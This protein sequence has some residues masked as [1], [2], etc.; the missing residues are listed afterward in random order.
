MPSSGGLETFGLTLVQAK[1]LPRGKRRSVAGYCVRHGF[2]EECRPLLEAAIAEDPNAML[3]RT[4][5]IHVLM[6]CGEMD[7]AEDLSARLLNEFP[8]NRFVINTRA[9]VLLTLGNEEAARQVF[10]DSVGD[11][12]V[13]WTYWARAG[14]AAHRRRGWDEARFAL[15]KALA[16]YRSR[17]DEDVDEQSIPIYLWSALAEQADHD[18]ISPNLF[19]EELDAVR[20]AEQQ[21]IRAALASP[22]SERSSQ[23][24]R[25][26]TPRH[27]PPSQRAVDPEI[28]AILEES[29][30][31][32][33][34]NPALAAE[35]HRLFGFDRFR[36]GQQKVVELVIKGE[37]VLAV[38]PTGAGKSLCYQLP[39]MMLEGVTL[40]VSP[41]IALM[42]DQVDGLPAEVQRQVT[43]INSTLEGDEIE[44]RMREIRAGKYKLV[45]AAPERLRQRPFLHALKARGVGLLV[46]D[47]AHCVSMWGH[48]FR[49]DYL[50]IGDALRYLG[51]PTVLA[52]TATATPEMRVEISNYFGRRLN[53]VST[54][55]H[56]PNLFLESIMVSTDEHKMREL[57]RLCRE[58][59]GTGIVYTRSRQKTEELTRL[60]RREGVKAAYYHA[61]MEG[62]ERARVHEEFMDGRWR[63]IVATVAFGMGID[64]PDVRFV[65]HYSLP[66]SLEDYY[67]EAGRAGR[68]S[69]TSRCIL[70]CTPADKRNVTRWMS[71]ERVDIGLPRQCYQMIREMTGGSRFAAIH[72]DDFERE[73]QQEQTKVRVA[74]SMLDGVGLVKRHLDVPMTASVTLT[75]KG[76]NGADAEFSDFAGNARL[77]VAQRVPLEPLQLAARAGIAPD[78]LEEK[79]LDW[80]DAGYLVY[81]GSGRV[82][83]L[84]R[85]VAAKDSK[86]VLEDMIAKRARVQEKRIEKTFHYAETNRCRHDVIAEHF[87]EPRIEN[88]TFCDNC[89][90]TRQPYEPVSKQARPAEPNLTDSEKDRKIIETVRMIPGKVGFTGLVKVLKGSVAS[91]IKRDRCPNFGILAN[92]PKTTIERR[93]TRLI[94]SGE[95]VRDDGEYRLI[96][97]KK[98]R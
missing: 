82:M 27:E 2:Y 84:E 54:G 21:K 74:I 66:A 35:L 51:D 89:V 39:A 72:P 26:S 10:I 87:G 48:D 4:W 30:R 44:R 52:M 58:I 7:E 12:E 9:E 65:I 57:L 25:R 85:L 73:F 68:D 80:Q 13:M 56:R 24:S 78:N 69:L 11:P 5:K 50:F 15:D 17:G 37:S 20:A 79:L 42:K 93:V 16:L 32:P 55:T 92:E 18:G 76:A 81:R 40:V 59:D 14:L 95:L 1:N 49:P 28:A 97:P 96:W 71:A 41:L 86:R 77:R 91:H 22:G 19:R 75:V 31:D 6:G 60:L 61:G 90:P 23:P 64:K 29:A 46:V 63:V 62:E 67:Q 70:L 8:V 43:L 3:Y 38:M 88:C 47:E 34:A 94:E 33:D 83:L 98:A 53:I 45:Y 36:V